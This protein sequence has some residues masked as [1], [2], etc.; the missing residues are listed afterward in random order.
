VKAF[1]VS[2]NADGAIEITIS[3]WAHDLMMEIYS[4][5]P[6]VSQAK[7][8]RQV[9]EVENIPVQR[10][11]FRFVED[12]IRDPEMGPALE[13]L[14][15]DLR[16]MTGTVADDLVVT[17]AGAKNVA[18]LIAGL[19]GIATADVLAVAGSLVTVMW[20]AGVVI[21]DGRNLGQEIAEVWDSFWK[22]VAPDIQPAPA[23][24]F[25]NNSPAETEKT[26]TCAALESQVSRPPYP[27]LRPCVPLG[28]FRPAH[29]S[30]YRFPARLKLA[31][32]PKAHNSSVPR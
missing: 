2:K 8:R 26:R 23:T 1:K 32:D 19:E 3:K 27:Q 20:G 21:A 6:G 7:R 11:P 31:P 25:G 4:R 12:L 28:P 30:F 24:N 9:G 22:F 15:Q 13:V 5:I 17:F 10:R 18:A 29:P 16:A 14:A